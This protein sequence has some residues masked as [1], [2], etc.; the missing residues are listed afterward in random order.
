VQA[1]RRSAVS[2]YSADS[3]SGCDANR[4]KARLDLLLVETIHRNTKIGTHRFAAPA[5]AFTERNA[6]SLESG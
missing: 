5:T 3:K 4:E 2:R 1:S 6:D